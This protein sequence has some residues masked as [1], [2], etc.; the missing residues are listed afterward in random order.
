MIFHVTEP[1]R[2]QRSLAEGIHTGSTLGVDLAEEGFI[3]CSTVEQWPGV[4]DRF[5][6]GAPELVLL[7]VDETK[8]TA[9]LRWEAAAGSTDANAELFPHIYGPI[10]LEAV[11]HVETVRAGNPPGASI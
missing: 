1:A 11:V 4:I 6:V 10:D 7:H 2:W 8:L 5:Y 3:H 9:P